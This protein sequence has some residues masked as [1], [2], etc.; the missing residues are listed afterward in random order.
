M[1]KIGSVL[2][3]DLLLQLGYVYLATLDLLQFSHLAT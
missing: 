3:A 1:E 2:M